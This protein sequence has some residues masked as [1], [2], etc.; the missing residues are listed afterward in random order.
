[1][2]LHQNIKHIAVLVNGAPEV[3]A[4]P[5]DVNK[6]LVHVPRADRARLP[7]L[8]HPGKTLTEFEAP[9]PDGL[10]GDHNATRSKQFLYISEAQGKAEVRPD[11]MT[12][13]FVW[14]TVASAEIDRSI[15]PLIMPRPAFLAQ[16]D[17]TMA[18]LAM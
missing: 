9:L 5:S 16:L 8:K 3:V 11:G 18:N 13:N 14:V 17:S 2:R 6:D 7:A 1:M 15:Y 12:D 4:P 10:V